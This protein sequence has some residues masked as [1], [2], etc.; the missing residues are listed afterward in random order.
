MK[1]NVEPFLKR[2]KWLKSVPNILTVCNSLCGFGA[3]LFA[4]QAYRN[5]DMDVVFITSACLILGA[6]VFDTLDGFA[7]RILNAASLKGVQM[8]S[9]AD[10]VTFGVAPAV[11]V[12]VMAHVYSATQYGY[13]IAW[14]LC[15][16]YL[17]TAAHRLA[18]YNVMTMVEKK[19]GQKFY[20]LPSPGGAAAVCS[21]VIL[22]CSTNIDPHH[23]WVKIL[24]YYACLMGILMVSNIRF[25][26][27]GKWLINAKRNK[28]RF[29]LLLVVLVLLLLDP[30]ACVV[31]VIN[32]YVVWGIVR[33]ISIRMNRR[34]KMKELRG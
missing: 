9:L 28:I 15:A 13:V 5:T 19:S 12:A 7:A 6:M 26:H 11:L 31:I 25:Q 10:M 23:F 18:R 27:M 30:V 14:L 8:D 29:C 22:F 16:I 34:K 3:I 2:N 4:L 1:K 21:L 33:D 24:P 20:G 32:G 17:A